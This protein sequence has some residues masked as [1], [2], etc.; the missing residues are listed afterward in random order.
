MHTSLPPLSSR[1]KEAVFPGK[2]GVPKPVYFLLLP[3]CWLGWPLR[4]RSRKVDTMAAQEVR[5]TAFTLT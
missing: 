3:S 1:Y 2:Y 4:D 5:G